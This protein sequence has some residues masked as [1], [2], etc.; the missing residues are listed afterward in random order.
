MSDSVPQGPEEEK[1][2]VSSHVDLAKLIAEERKLEAEQREARLQEQ[3]EKDPEGLQRRIQTM[4]ALLLGEDK[5]PAP[6][7][8]DLGKKRELIRKI[9]KEN[10]FERELF[11]KKDAEPK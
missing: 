7:G 11:E 10:N 9:I 2:P 4:L 6:P 3:K 1:P 5:H 8:E